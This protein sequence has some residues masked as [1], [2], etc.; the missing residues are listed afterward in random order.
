[1]NCV[2][3]Q[4]AVAVCESMVLSYEMTTLTKIQFN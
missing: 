3:E 2:A 4:N 1:M